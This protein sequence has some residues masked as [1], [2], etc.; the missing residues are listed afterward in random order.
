MPSEHDPVPAA[1]EVLEDDGAVQSA[2]TKTVTIDPGTNEPYADGS[3]KVKTSWLLVE[4]AT[5]VVG[6]TVIVPFPL[7]AAGTTVTEGLAAIKAPLP[8]PPSCVVVKNVAGPTGP[9]V[10]RFPGSP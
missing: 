3:V 9:A 6:E 5:A 10:T 1:T 8:P 2:G 4:E 7:A